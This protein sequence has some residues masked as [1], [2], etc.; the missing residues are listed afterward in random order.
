LASDTQVL[1]AQGQYVLVK[2]TFNLT[3]TNKN[4]AEGN[5]LQ[6]QLIR[7]GTSA[8]DTLN[9]DIYVILVDVYKG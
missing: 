6:L 7:N 5:L 8:D 9:G 1:A 3:A 4:V 2:T